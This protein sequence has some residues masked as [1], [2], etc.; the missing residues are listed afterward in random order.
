MSR[1]VFIALILTSTVLIVGTAGFWVTSMTPPAALEAP[2][3]VPVDDPE[4][5]H[6]EEFFSGD[7]DRD[8]RGGQEMRP[9][10]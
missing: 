5:S 8:L 1:S 3:D 4:H 6:A 10:W 2:G 7:P 9:R